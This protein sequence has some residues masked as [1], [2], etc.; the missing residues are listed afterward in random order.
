MTRCV[1]GM[2]AWIALMRSMSRISPVGG[3]VNLYAPCDVPIATASASTPVFAT[4]S[5]AWLG[6]GQEL[7]MIEHAFGAR[8]VFLAGRAGFER[9]EAPE[10]AFD[11]DADRVRHVDDAARDHH[12]VFVGRRRLH[13]FLQRAVHHDAGEAGADRRL[14]DG[15]TRA[16]ILMQAHG[17]LR[18]L[19]DRREHEMTQERLAGIAS[20]AGRCLQDHRTVD[21]LGG[22]HDRVD[23]LHVVDVERGQAI[24]VLG[25]VVEEL[26]ERDEG[27]GGG[28]SR[29]ISV[30]P[31][32]RLREKVPA[33]G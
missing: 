6:I 21:F 23:L 22:L 33:G 4:K 5:A 27:H 32:S 29:G 13:V 14:A 20:R 17:N 30:Y 25:G 7:R 31:F 8:A 28:L 18:I 26:L 9:A 3:R 15:G 1:D 16:V 10:L 12:V 24:G 11:A 19:L 2:R